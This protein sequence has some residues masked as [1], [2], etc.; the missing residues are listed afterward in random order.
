MRSSVRGHFVRYDKAKG[1]EEKEK[2]GGRGPMHCMWAFVF[3]LISC[4][5]YARFEGDVRVGL[6]KQLPL[7]VKAIFQETDRFGKNN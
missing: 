5:A 7:N 2:G 3:L 6:A 1:F 4:V